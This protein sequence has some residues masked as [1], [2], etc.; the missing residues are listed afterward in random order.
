MLLQPKLTGNICMVRMQYFGPNIPIGLP[1]QHFSRLGGPGGYLGDL[2][3]HLKTEKSSEN[4]SLRKIRCLG[5]G[6]ATQT[7][8][9][10]GSKTIIPTP[11]GP[12]PMAHMII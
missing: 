5:A 9:N 1:R 11:H 2:K 4:R 6:K 8:P 7:P 10:V 3:H 12:K